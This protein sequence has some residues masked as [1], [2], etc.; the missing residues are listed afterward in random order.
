V[1][2]SDLWREKSFSQI[3]K[4]SFP[5]SISQLSSHGRPGL[6]FQ[7]STISVRKGLPPL[8]IPGIHAWIDESS[9]ISDHSIAFRYLLNSDPSKA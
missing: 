4:S 7:V 3:R 8:M 9:L 5:F 1:P 6:T 2:E